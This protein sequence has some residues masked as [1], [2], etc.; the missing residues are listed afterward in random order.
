MACTSSNL[1]LQLP[2]L[3]S[4]QDGSL[5]PSLWQRE[6]CHFMVMFRK[7]RLLYRRLTPVFSALVGDVYVATYIFLFTPGLVLSKRNVLSFH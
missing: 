7:A 2:W 4:C 3:Y 6:R 1:S 5:V